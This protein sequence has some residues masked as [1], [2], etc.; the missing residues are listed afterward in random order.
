MTTTT[1]RLED[2]ANAEIVPNQG[3]E[4]AWLVRFDNDTYDLVSKTTKHRLIIEDDVLN[5]SRF[6]IGDYTIGVDWDNDV[7]TMRKA[8]VSDTVTVPATAHTELL[9]AI[10]HGDTLSA[11]AV[12]DEHHVP[13]VRRGLV[14]ML[15]P[16]FT[17]KGVDI[18]RTD[19]GWIVEGEILVRWDASN[20]IFG[21]TQTF[22]VSGD[23]VTSS[24]TPTP[25]R[26][27]WFSFPENRDVVLPNGETTALDE[28]E[29][30]FLATVGHIGETQTNVDDA[31]AESIRES[32]TVAFT[33]TLSGLYHRHAMDK[34]TLSMLDVTDEAA[35]QLEY[36]DYD[37]AGV[38]E[39]WHRRSEFENADFDVFTTGANDSVSH[40]QE[41][42]NARQMAPIPQTVKSKLA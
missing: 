39:M 14:N 27:F 33:D 23:D 20:E 34:H 10:R 31:I 5:Q 26:E 3:G 7:Y 8:G 9:L 24:S 28:V 13:T 1:Y 16:R 17:E 42:D 15:M 6:T 19:A 21:A 36:H 40:W 32:K 22:E 29:L 30:A 11:E 12:F 38:H 41:I 2:L 25:A 4:N 37:H 18:A 35:A